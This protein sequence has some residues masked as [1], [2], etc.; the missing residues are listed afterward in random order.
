MARG[1]HST[2]NVDSTTDGLR[3]TDGRR[4]TEC[5]RLDDWPTGKLRQPMSTT[6]EQAPRSRERQS[7]RRA[8][9]TIQEA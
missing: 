6:H 4:T 7:R 5:L 8:R 9:A 1:M 2:Q 3:T